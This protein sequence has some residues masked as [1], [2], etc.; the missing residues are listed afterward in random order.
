MLWTLLL[1]DGFLVAFALEVLLLDGKQMGIM[2]MFASEVGVHTTLPAAWA[3]V[4]DAVAPTDR[5]TTAVHDPH[6]D[7]VIYY[8]QIHHQRPGHALGSAMGG[9]EHA[10]LLR[11][12]RHR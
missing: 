8:R 5:F 6:S 2:I 7:T 1:L 11:G 9:K 4:A 10:C 3:A 12:P